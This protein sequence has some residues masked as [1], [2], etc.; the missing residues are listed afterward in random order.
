MELRS[1]PFCGSKIEV[2]DE[3]IGQPLLSWRPHC[4]NSDCILAAGTEQTF[5]AMDDLADAW[6]TRPADGVDELIAAYDAYIELLNKEIS[7][8]IGIC[9][10]HGWQSEL[11]EEGKMARERIAKARA[12]LKEE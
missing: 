5:A 10:V 11:A 9:F 1:C 7:S 2:Y 8:M 6:N 4:S 12:A 3:N